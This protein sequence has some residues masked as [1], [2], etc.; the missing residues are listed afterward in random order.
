MFGAS[1]KQP[2]P[3]RC[4]PLRAQRLLRLHREWR[5]LLQ[6]LNSPAAFRRD[7]HPA[8]AAVA[9]FEQH[10]LLLI[11]HCKLVLQ[12]Q[13]QNSSVCITRL[14]A[15]SRSLQHAITAL[16]MPN[17]SMRLISSLP[18]S[19]HGEPS[20]PSQEN[21]KCCNFTQLLEKSKRILSIY[22]FLLG[23]AVGVSCLR[24]TSG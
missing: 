5:A 21:V 17:W 18:L 11:M 8:A 12:A 19:C 14:L 10:Q 1:G 3:Q 24:G 4:M 9:A 15:W 13:D 20:W 2:H 16:S 6:A 23:K 22:S 7:L